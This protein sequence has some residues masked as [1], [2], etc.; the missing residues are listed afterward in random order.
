[1]RKGLTLEDVRSWG[2]WW[3]F[4]VFL[5]LDSDSS[6]LLG[7]EFATPKDTVSVCLSVSPMVS[8][9]VRLFS[10]VFVLL[11]EFYIRFE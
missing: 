6:F 1:M 8:S 9:C 3:G 4:F 2:S 10:S 11:A 5:L 7:H